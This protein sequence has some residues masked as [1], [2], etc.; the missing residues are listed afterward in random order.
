MRTSIDTQDNIVPRHTTTSEVEVII[1]QLAPRKAP[2][3]DGITNAVL[4][5]LERKGVA[6]LTNL[7]NSA[8]RLRHYLNQWK[9][10]NVIALPKPGQNLSLP[11]SYRPISLLSGIGKILERVILRRFQ[12]STTHQLLRAREH[13]TQRFNRKQAIDAI[14][15]DIARAFDKVWHEGLIYKLLHLYSPNWLTRIIQSFLQNQMFCIQL[16]TTTST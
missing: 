8:L 7:F 5:N 6:A 12:N 14:F 9:T 2:G 10:T 1:N 3:P 15:L 11:Q 16:E 13:I 4:K